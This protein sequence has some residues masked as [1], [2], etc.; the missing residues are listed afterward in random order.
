MLQILPR[1]T[2]ELE[3]AIFPILPE[4]ALFVGTIE[5][6]IRK[7]IRLE[8]GRASEEHNTEKK[9]YRIDI[10]SCLIIISKEM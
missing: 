1:F 5:G 3:N 4:S 6:R 10:L 8:T 7:E 2:N 9:E